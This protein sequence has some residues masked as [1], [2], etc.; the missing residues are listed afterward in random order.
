MYEVKKLGDFIIDID[1]FD[2][3]S[4]VQMI[5]AAFSFELWHEV[6]RFSESLYIRINKLKED[7]PNLILKRPLVYYY[8]YALLMKGSAFKKLRRFDEAKECIRQYSDLSWFEN[9]DQAGLEEV[10]Y[11]AYISLPNLLE[12]E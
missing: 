5:K 8:G 11:Y 6:I 3:D 1:Q 2:Y 10:N 9:L 7:K 12:I 4:T